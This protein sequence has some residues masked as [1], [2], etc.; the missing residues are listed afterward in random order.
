MERRASVGILLVA[1]LAAGCGTLADAGNESRGDDELPSAGVA[2]WD[3]VDL[4]GDSTNLIQPWLIESSDS[5]AA[6]AE[7][8]L[9]RDAAG[10]VLFYTRGGDARSQGIWRT[11]ASDPEALYHAGAGGRVLE[12]TLDWERGR[13]GG[14]SVVETNVATASA[15]FRLW[16]AGGNGAGIGLAESEDGVRWSKHGPPVLVA[17]QPW[18]QG[19]VASPSV[20]RVRDEWWLWYE[21]GDG[22]GIG[23]ARSA[24]GVSWR[25]A[26]VAHPDGGSTSDVVGPVFTPALA[27]EGSSTN[28]VAPGHVGAPG[29]L[30][31]DPLGGTRFGLYYT[32]YVPIASNPLTGEESSDATPGTR[33]RSIGYA[34][35]ADGLR[36]TRA[37]PS[38]NP[39]VAERTPVELGE[40]PFPPELAAALP[41]VIL[42]LLRSVLG[43][44]DQGNPRIPAIE[45]VIDEGDAAVIA[46]G[47][48]RFTMVF[49]QS[50]SL[51]VP[52][53]LDLPASPVTV[54]LGVL[55]ADSRNGIALARSRL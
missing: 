40:V 36:W 14:A 12:A 18:E 48:N 11:E 50:N 4:D 43:S 42:A 20:A 10:V 44:D 38:I 24:D 3:K 2:P 35:S 22:A 30:V 28:G 23:F 7:P 9:I 55:V 34:A 53:A 16:Y 27:W 1:W 41:D 33:N 37:D 26:D 15:R 49:T 21:G 46:D 54:P 31:L 25:K 51:F 13:V 17:D 19:R 45:L 47:P 29:V 6:L 32:G 8:A 39:V 52:L 5:H